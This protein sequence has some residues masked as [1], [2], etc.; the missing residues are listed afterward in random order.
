[1]PALSVS[2]SACR[3]LANVCEEAHPMEACGF[4]LG[5][6]QDG[7][8]VATEIVVGRES[9]PERDRFAI[10]D[11]ELRR[12]AAYAEDRGLRILALFHS[13]PSGDHT[14]SAGDRAALRHSAWPWVIV[15]RPRGAASV[16]LTTY[17]HF[18]PRV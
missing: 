1:M 8:A 9:A 16:V 14:L 4:L 5:A 6:V 13:H 15:T 17:E 18:E 12:M 10:P 2:P 11:H 3:A 7:H